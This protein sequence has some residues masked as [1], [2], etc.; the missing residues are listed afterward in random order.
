MDNGLFITGTDTGVGKT[1][2]GIGL[3]RA[4]KEMG[5]TVCPFKPLESGCSRK[6]GVLIP[7]DACRLM[8]ASDVTEQIDLINP[9]RFRQPLA[10]SVAA[11]LEGI[12]INKKRLISVYKQLARKYDITI[13]EG[14]GGIMV[15]VYKKY[16]FID[17]ARDLGLPV[18]IV[19]RP[20]LGTINHTLLTL[21]ALKQRGLKIVGVIINRTDKARIDQSEKTNPGIIEALS[22]VP[23]L[24]NVPYLGTS[25]NP[26]RK[27]IFKD[28][29]ERIIGG[30]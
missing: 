7:G 17:L 26:R 13:V 21:E 19:S 14:A 10:P 28:I 8:R 20:G 25:K 27:K 1:F 4:I 29:A 6:R 30:A 24:G 12:K 23:V 22:G 5:K 18:V 15:P 16:L 11:E 2:V 3:I 9:Y